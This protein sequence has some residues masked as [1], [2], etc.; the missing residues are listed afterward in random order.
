MASMHV[1]PWLE[2]CKM[3][4]RSMQIWVWTYIWTMTVAIPIMG[5]IMLF[6]TTNFLARFLRC[7]DLEDVCISTFLSLSPLQSSDHI[8]SL[9]THDLFL[10]IA[11]NYHR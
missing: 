9:I 10:S 6:D 4:L 7:F 5:R 1:Q 2:H 11:H 8:H 3:A